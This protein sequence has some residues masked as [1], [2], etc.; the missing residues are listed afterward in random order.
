MD[1]NALARTN[2]VIEDGQVEFPSINLLQPFSR[3]RALICIGEEH[4]VQIMSEAFEA[5]QK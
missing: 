4:N 1:R 5:M 2:F 3:T